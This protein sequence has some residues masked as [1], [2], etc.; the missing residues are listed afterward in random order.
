LL[1]NLAARQRQTTM[2]LLVRWVL[3]AIALMVISHFL[4]G[5]YVTG[6]VAA[7]IAAAVIGFV[8][9]TLGTV[10]KFLTFPLTVITLGLFLIVINA[11]LLKVAAFFSPGFRV[12]TWSAAF[13]GAILLSLVSAFLHHVLDD[14]RESR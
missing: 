6:F 8:N 2:K 9:A 14:R 1:A 11:V 10:L 12:S 5:F 7:L 4:R 3:S 13:I